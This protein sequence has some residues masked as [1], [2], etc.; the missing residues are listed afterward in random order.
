MD[1]SSALVIG[2]NMHYPYNL[3][4]ELKKNRTATVSCVFIFQ[5]PLLCALLCTTIES[6]KATRSIATEKIEYPTVPTY[7]LKNVKES[8]YSGS[9]RDIALHI[10]S[11][12]SSRSS[13]VSGRSINEPN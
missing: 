9:R 8:F 6:N 12:S 3:N 7:L 10:Y 1:S 11:S 13:S 2:V 4:F 5:N